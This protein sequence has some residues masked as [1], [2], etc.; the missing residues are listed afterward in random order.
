VLSGLGE[1]P[2]LVRAGAQVVVQDVGQL[3]QMLLSPSS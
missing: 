2:E 3:A 1:R